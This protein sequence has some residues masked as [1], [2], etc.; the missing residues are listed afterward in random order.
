M[1]WPPAAS[2]SAWSRAASRKLQAQNDAMVEMDKVRI[3]NI[4]NVAMHAKK[5]KP[6]AKIGIPW[7][8]QRQA[9]K[10]R[11]QVNAYSIP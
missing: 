9:D 5:N 2:R 4:M 7:D 11:M 10:S 8:S 6:L 3:A 1:S